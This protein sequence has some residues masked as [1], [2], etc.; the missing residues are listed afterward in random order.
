MGASK[1]GAII[2]PLSA[3]GLDFQKPIIYIIHTKRSVP[4]DSEE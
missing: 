2:F 1:K 3:K 4:H